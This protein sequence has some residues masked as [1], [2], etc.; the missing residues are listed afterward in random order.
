MMITAGAL[1][2]GQAHGV[3][4]PILL[5]GTVCL[6]RV[7]SASA[8]A[9]MLRAHT[10][11]WR[12]GARANA[13]DVVTGVGVATG[14]EEVAGVAVMDGFPCVVGARSDDRRWVAS[15]LAA[16]GRGWGHPRW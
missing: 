1:S 9:A 3:P 2:V 16:G 5:A 10:A 11:A 14:S 12:R 6:A 15:V 8:V 4:V 13:A 7:S